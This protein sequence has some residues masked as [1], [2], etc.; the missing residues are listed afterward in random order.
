MTPPPPPRPPPRRERLLHVTDFAPEEHE[1]LAGLDR[2]DLEDPDLRLLDDG[3]GGLQPGG[4]AAVLDEGQRRLE[5]ESRRVGA[6]W[7]AS[8]PPPPPPSPCPWWSQR[9]GDVSRGR[10]RISWGDG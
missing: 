4:D 6:N 10:G 7:V 8:V 3:V 1:E 2:P 9:P 5:D